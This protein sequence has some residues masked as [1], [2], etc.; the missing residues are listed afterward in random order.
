MAIVASLAFIG[1]RLGV[2]ERQ[3]ITYSPRQRITWAI[4]FGVI[5]L[6]GGGH[7]LFGVGL[8]AAVYFSGPRYNQYRIN[9]PIARNC[10]ITKR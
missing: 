6:L 1:I 5:V 9:R 2:I 10:G 8:G 3:A 4:A 7:L